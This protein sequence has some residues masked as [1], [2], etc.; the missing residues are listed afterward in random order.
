MDR[1]LIYVLGVVKG[2]VLG[3]AVATLIV[4]KINTEDIKAYAIQTEQA[5]YDSKSGE[6]IITEERIRK[7]L[8][9]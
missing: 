6:L 4:N 9:E 3:L 8:G 7:L 2:F 1:S 5:Y